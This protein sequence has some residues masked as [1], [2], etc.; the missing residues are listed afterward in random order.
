MDIG[1]SKNIPNTQTI[2]CRVRG[3]GLLPQGWSLTSWSEHENAVYH[4]QG[5]QTCRTPHVLNMNHILRNIDTVRS[6][7]NRQ[8]VR[9]RGW[10][11]DL[12]HIYIVHCTELAIPESL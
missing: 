2:P 11:Y 12:E 9:I 5:G 3:A 7:D 8:A 6:W 10:P 1:A 4:I